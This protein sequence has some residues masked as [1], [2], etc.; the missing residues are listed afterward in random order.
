MTNNKTRN[1]RTITTNATEIKRIIR[2][3]YKQLCE[4]WIIQ[5]KRI[6]SEKHTT[7]QNQIMKKQ[8]I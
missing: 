5:K 4:N 8:K 2:D 3:Y 6:N 1:E 7:Y